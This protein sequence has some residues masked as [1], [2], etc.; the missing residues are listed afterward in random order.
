[1][2]KRLPGMG[3]DTLTVYLDGAAVTA[4]PGDCAASVLLRHAP[5][6]ARRSPLSGRPRAPFCMMGVCMDCAAVVDGVPSTL[7][8]QTVVR[9][10]MTIE[11]Q[12]TL[13]AVDKG[14]SDV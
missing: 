10:G 4:R 2:F 7:T 6:F 14:G 9:E 8:C 11:R 1:L 12:V 5:Y 3:K 13:P